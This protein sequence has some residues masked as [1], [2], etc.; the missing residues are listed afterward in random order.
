MENQGEGRMTGQSERCY[1]RAF[2]VYRCVLSDGHEGDHLSWPS[3]RELDL[4]LRG[5]VERCNVCGD[6][7][8]ARWLACVG[9]GRDLFLSRKLA[10]VEAKDKLGAGEFPAGQYH[11][12]RGVAAKRLRGQLA[13]AKAEAAGLR[14]EVEAG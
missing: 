1:F 8:G 12:G 3:E 7:R 6:V 11:P 4:G 14:R 10:Q 13:E 9:C 2:G 5:S